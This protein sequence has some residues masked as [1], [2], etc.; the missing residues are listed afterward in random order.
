MKTSDNITITDGRLKKALQDKVE[1][2]IIPQIN[3]KVNKTARDAKIQVA[4]MTKF[5]PYLDKCEVDLD[6]SLVICKIL[7]RFSG[8]LID[9]YTPLGNNDYCERLHEPCIIPLET[10]KCLILDIND[11]SA[12]QVMIGYFLP[13]EII[14]MDPATA[15]NLKLTSMGAT[16]EY[17]ITFGVSGLD[18]RSREMPTTNVGEFDSNMTNLEYVTKKDIEDLIIGEVADLT[19]IKQHLDELEEKV[20][21]IPSG[22]IDLS[23]YVRKDD[24]LDKTKYDI[25]LN[26]SFG[27]K[28]EDDTIVID[29]DIV[30]HIVDKTIDL[31]GV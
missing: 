12:E 8:E 10:L 18:I 21:N 17:W 22:E 4:T 7:H 16:N 13:D 2:V 6:G 30:D 31:R 1:K 20:D 25:D 9:F 15:G 3:S 11:G 14:G 29:M 19:E 27:L 5:Y 24:L 28:G 23:E 26:L